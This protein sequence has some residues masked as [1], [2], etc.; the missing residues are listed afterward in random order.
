MH[1]AQLNI[2]TL[3]A[4]IDD[5]RIAGF[6][7][8]L[9]AMN[10]LAE[11]SPGFVWRMKDDSNNVTGI[12]TPSSVKIRVIPAFRPTTPIVITKPQL[13]SSQSIQFN[14]YIYASGKIQFH[15]RINRFVSRV[16]D[17]HEALVRPDFI[18]VTRILVDMR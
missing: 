5:P 16:N 7:D 18:L 10:A 14:L 6:K 11:E 12:E 17:I 3:T 1:L 2:G 4:P 8:N 9:D 15:E 13:L